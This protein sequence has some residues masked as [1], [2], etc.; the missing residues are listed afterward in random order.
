MIFPQRSWKSRVKAA[1][2]SG[3]DDAASFVA[4]FFLVLLID[5]V[6]FDRQAISRL[7]DYQQSTAV[8]RIE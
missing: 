1:S 8:A 3:V 6:R 7:V 4:C 2:S 5:R